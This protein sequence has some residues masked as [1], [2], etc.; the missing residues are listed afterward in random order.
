MRLEANGKKLVKNTP[1]FGVLLVNDRSLRYAD[2]GQNFFL[3]EVLRDCQ[4]PSNVFISRAY[5]GRVIDTATAAGKS[6]RGNPGPE[7]QQFVLGG[8]ERKAGGTC[9][10]PRQEWRGEKHGCPSK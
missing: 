1:A 7:F 2:A 3:R 8:M 9:H 5:E 6:T 10:D 4:E